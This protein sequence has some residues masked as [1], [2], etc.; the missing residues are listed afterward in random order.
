MSDGVRVVVNVKPGS[1]R[2]GISLVDGTLQVRVSAPAHEGRANEA[3]TEALSAHLM[4]PRSALRLVRGFRA[5]IKTFE[6]QGVDEAELHRR[7]TND[8]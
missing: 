3:V 1:R 6:V 8:V 5:H 4:L 7:M 2:P